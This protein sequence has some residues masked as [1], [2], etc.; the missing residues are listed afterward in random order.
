MIQP[1]SQL[2][3]RLWRHMSPRRRGQFGLL[4]VLMILASFAEVLSIGAV[5]PFLAI[6]TDPTRV[7]VHPISQPVVKLLEITDPQQLLLPLTVAFGVAV[8]IAA[9]LRLLL[10]WA[11]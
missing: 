5:L 2:L 8:L 1:I 9:A 7:F 10:L 4:L 6:L 3:R 11:T